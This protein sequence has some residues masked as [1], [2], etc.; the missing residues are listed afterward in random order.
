MQIGELSA[1]TAA[2][3]RMLRYYEEQGLLSPK[4]TESGYRIYDETDVLR[5]VRLERS[6]ECRV[7]RCGDVRAVRR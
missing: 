7:A 1:R 6:P 5:V 2:T 3:V 4:R